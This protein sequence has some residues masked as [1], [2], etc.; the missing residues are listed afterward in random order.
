[1]VFH[2]QM[3]GRLSL[4][5][6][7]VSLLYAQL[8]MACGCDAPMGSSWYGTPQRKTDPNYG[9]VDP[10]PPPPPP[11]PPLTPVFNQFGLMRKAIAIKP[12]LVT[13]RSFSS[14]KPDG[15]PLKW[16]HPYFIVDTFPDSKA[17]PPSL[18]QLTATPNATSSVGW[19]SVDDVI[20]WPTR[21]AARWTKTTPLLVAADFNALQT[22][23]RSGQPIVN[24]V[25]R[26]SGTN[27][28][29]WM[30]WPIL[31]SRTFV[32][33]GV[34]YECARLAFLAVGSS[35]TEKAAYSEDEVAG[36]QDRLR[37][38]SVT[39][40]VD[41]TLSTQ[42]Q[43]EAMTAALTRIVEQ[44]RGLPDA[45]K[46]RCSVVLYRDYIPGLYF[47]ESGQKRVVREFA[48]TDDLE[49]LIEELRRIEAA[50]QDSLDLAESVY[51][52]VDAGLGLLDDEDKLSMKVLI[53]CGDN[54]AHLPGTR[55]NPRKIAA[56]DLIDRARAQKTTIYSLCVA[57]GGDVKERTMHRSQ[58]EALAAGTKGECHSLDESDKIIDAIQGLIK[59]ADDESK[60]RRSELKRLAERSAAEAAAREKTRVGTPGFETVV[61]ELL[62]DAN[63]DPERLHAEDG[64]SSMPTST[65]GWVLASVDGQSTAQTIDQCVFL[66]RHEINIVLAELQSLNVVLSAKS[67]SQLH[68]LLVRAKTGEFLTKA[69]ANQSFDSFMRANGIPARSGLLRFSKD[70]I[71]Q[72]SDAR[73]KEI[74]ELIYRHYIP[75]IQRARNDDRNFRTQDDM[76]ITF[77]M[78]DIFP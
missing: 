63:I 76:E 56:E 51:D 3:I 55:G 46:L 35:R 69:P 64:K 32:H 6:I 59:S 29:A 72:M 62:R 70:D 61:M 17:G 16:F 13:R 45:P 58:F 11:T 54:S 74:S 38:L 33:D 25:A 78:A 42:P 67:T 1:M 14:E 75:E 19:V 20:E 10:G 7:S 66:T 18:F 37:T 41:N 39:F 50:K 71:M 22:S 68:E 52:G 34:S 48:T 4:Q 30:P 23:L 60:Q 9:E 49:S 73:R 8:L 47:E 77:V 12:N 36:F 31:E 21:M 57:G 26:F 24:P 40:V 43:V 65:T 15:E 53:L 44:L 2:Q 28:D 27:T 5:I